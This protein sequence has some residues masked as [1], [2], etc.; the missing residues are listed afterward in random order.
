MN[1]LE[2]QIFW[3]HFKRIKMLDTYLDSISILIENFKKR[4][5]SPA[6]IAVYSALSGMIGTVILIAFFSMMLSGSSLYA[7]L[8]I[9]IAF[10]AAN[11]GFCLV[12]K[13]GT[14]FPRLKLTMIVISILIVI[15]GFVFMAVL[16]PWEVM[17]Y[18]RYLFSGVVSLAF[19]FFG[20]W[21]ARK[22][23]NTNRKP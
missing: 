5:A 2:N 20:A 19:S 22:S 3:R 10:N 23:K 1:M 9:I 14:G 12:E 18:T 21:L 4:L 13:G 15:S 6:G 17:L 11:S 16:V 8:P 7:I